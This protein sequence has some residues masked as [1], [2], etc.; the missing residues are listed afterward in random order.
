MGR[1][2]RGR[3]QAGTGSSEEEE[4]NPWGGLG[5]RGTGRERPG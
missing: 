2:E 3:V 4:L 1:V 5:S